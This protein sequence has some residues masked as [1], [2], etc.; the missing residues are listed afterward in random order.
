VI[1][2]EKKFSEKCWTHEFGILL[3]LAELKD[4]WKAEC[5][6]S[7]QLASNCLMHPSWTNPVDISGWPNPTPS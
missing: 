5:Q 6:T 7:P 2:K 3:E 1:F 4:T